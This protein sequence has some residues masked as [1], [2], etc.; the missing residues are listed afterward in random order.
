MTVRIA[1]AA[2]MV[3]GCGLVTSSVTPDV[4]GFVPFV[5]L[6]R[7]WLPAPARMEELA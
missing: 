7:S 1:I 2:L 6:V 4:T 3:V 5:R